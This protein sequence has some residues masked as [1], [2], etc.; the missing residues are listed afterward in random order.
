VKQLKLE[1]SSIRKFGNLELLSFKTKNFSIKPGQ[2]L[3]VYHPE[4]DDHLIP[5]YFISQ[6]DDVFFLK[7]SNANWEI[8]DQLIVKG[9]IGTGFSENSPFQ[10]LFCVSFGE[11]KGSLI[12]VVEK[13]VRIGK[14][15]AYMLEDINLVLPYSVEIV[16]P[17]TLEETFLWADRILIEVERDQME[18][19][20]DMLRKIMNSKIPT[21]ILVYCPIL[22][23]GVSQCSV[24]AVKS[25]KGWVQTC[26]QGTVFNLYDLEF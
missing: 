13:S 4:K 22:C 12:P 8:G 20:Q 25:K 3:I 9:P 11:S 7:P 6:L 10:N 5:I 1:I 26:Q 21:E 17:E 18:K 14:N 23:S 16:F 24:C 19:N 15:V 2:F